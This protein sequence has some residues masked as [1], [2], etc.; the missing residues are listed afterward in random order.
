[1]TALLSFFWFRYDPNNGIE[2]SG[3]TFNDSLQTFNLIWKFVFRVYGG[4]SRRIVSGRKRC[5]I[6]LQ[7][8]AYFV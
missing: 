5:N 2:Q 4:P 3:V 7:H 1:M 8:N 6:L